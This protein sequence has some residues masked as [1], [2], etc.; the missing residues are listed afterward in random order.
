MTEAGI[1]DT[2]PSI[3][4]VTTS[5]AWDTGVPIEEILVAGNWTSET[6]FE[7]FYHRR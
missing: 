2:P 1:K 6:T 5:T 4:A 7:R 3:R